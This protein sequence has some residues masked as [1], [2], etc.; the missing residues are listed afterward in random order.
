MGY[1]SGESG[2]MRRENYRETV[3]EDSRFLEALT[4]AAR[5]AKLQRRANWEKAP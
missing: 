2:S 3:R 4:A 5:R 1:G